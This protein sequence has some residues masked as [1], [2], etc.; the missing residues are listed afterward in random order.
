MCPR[1]TIVLLGAGEDS[2]LKTISLGLEGGV[3]STERIKESLLLVLLLLD[4]RSLS[5]SSSLIAILLLSEVFFCTDFVLFLRLLFILM[6]V[7]GVASI[8]PGASVQ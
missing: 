8:K 3:S 7:S 2:S 1:H 6:Q 4:F 5:S